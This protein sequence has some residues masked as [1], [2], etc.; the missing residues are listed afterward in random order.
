MNFDV[1]SFVL[2]VLLASSVSTPFLIQGHGK[3]LPCVL[4]VIV[5]SLTF[6]SMIHLELIFVFGKRM[7]LHFFTCAYIQAPFVGKTFFFKHFYLFI[8][9]AGSSLWLKDFS[10]CST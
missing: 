6:K 7:A 10:S 9:C 5:S 1:V 2:L 4:N 3:L 8:G